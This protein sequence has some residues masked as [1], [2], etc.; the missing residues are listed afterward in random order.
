MLALGANHVLGHGPH[1]HSSTYN[2]PGYNERISDDVR[3]GD[4]EP[5]FG[6]E[7]YSAVGTA[8]RVQSDTKLKRSVHGI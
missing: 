1:E 4:E 2:H 5:Q 7:T 3:T 6:S 8:G